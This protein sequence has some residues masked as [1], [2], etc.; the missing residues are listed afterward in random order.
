MTNC[1]TI[2]EQDVTPTD[3]P[4]AHLTKR[5]DVPFPAYLQAYQVSDVRYACV[6]LLPGPPASNRPTAT[7]TITSTTTIV[8]FKDK[9]WYKTPYP[10]LYS[11]GF[12]MG[13]PSSFQSAKPPDIQSSIP[14][15]VRT[16]SLT[17]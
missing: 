9:K 13:N 15:G 3:S 8:E 5:D 16:D 7:E 17:G 4:S 2:I 10:T 1:R 12:Q 6:V 14:T 11:R